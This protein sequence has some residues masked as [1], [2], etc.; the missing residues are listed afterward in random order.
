LSPGAGGGSPGIPARRGWARREGDRRL[1][2]TTPET[3]RALYSRYCETEARELLHLIPREGLRALWVRA[4]NRARP[5][6]DPPLREPPPEALELLWR[7]ARALLPLPPYEAWIHAY[8]ENRAAFLARMGIASAP[9]RE[10]PVTVA[11]CPV[12]AVWWA[13]LNLERRA[14]GWVGHL[15]FHPEPVGG[16]LPVNHPAGLRTADIFRG[17]S[18]EEIR[19]RFREFTGHTL[20]A[21]LRSVSPQSA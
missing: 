19:A 17:D 16:H 6:G 21:F 10:G 18:P 8:M 4:R 5:E 3:L 7:E 1:T 14:G 9:E 13:H 2:P 12:N 15:A 20:E 11:V